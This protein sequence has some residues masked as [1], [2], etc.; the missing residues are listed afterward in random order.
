MAKNKTAGCCCTKCGD[1]LGGSDTCCCSHTC[2]AICVTLEGGCDDDQYGTDDCSC[3]DIAT[4]YLEY[5]PETGS[6]HGEISCGDVTIDLEFVVKYCEYT[7][8]CVLC[9]ISDC[10]SD[11]Y[12][13]EYDGECGNAISCKTLSA[14][15]E[16]CIGARETEGDALVGGIE[17]EWDIDVSNCGDGSCTSFKLTTLCTPRIFPKEITGDAY[18]CGCTGC[19][20]LC[21]DLCIFYSGTECSDGNRVTIDGDT[22]RFEVAACDVGSNQNGRAISIQLQKNEYTGECEL[23]VIAPLVDGETESDNITIVPLNDCPD[24]PLTKIY[25]DELADEWFSFECWKC[26]GCTA[27]Y[28]IC[29]CSLPDTEGNGAGYVMPESFNVEYSYD[30]NQAGGGSGTL[31]LDQRPNNNRSGPCVWRGDIPITCENGSGTLRL[32]L[33]LDPAWTSPRCGWFL[34]AQTISG[35]CASAAPEINVGSWSTYDC[36]CEPVLL[37]FDFRYVDSGENLHFFTAAISEA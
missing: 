10:L 30:D 31:T 17:H 23:K 16:S 33:T 35:N 27:R 4:T 14:G 15:T 5:D 13:D 26:N 19:K 18:G 24:I 1:R 8:E 12:G 20:C 36:E 7:G 28:C 6:Y 21:Q 2:H 9:L 37:N 32:I 25:V 22:W 29:H 3:N 34:T 11:P